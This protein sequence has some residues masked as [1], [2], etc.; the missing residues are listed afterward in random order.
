MSD[1]RNL[2]KKTALFYLLGTALKK[3]DET[4]NEQTLRN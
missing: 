2:L 1:L 4:V 3:A